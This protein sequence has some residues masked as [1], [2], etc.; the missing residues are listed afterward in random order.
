MNDSDIR[1]TI[2]IPRNKIRI[3]KSTLH[4]IN[5][6]THIVLV[7]NPEERTLGLKQCSPDEKTAHRINWKVMGNN[8]CELSSKSL[9]RAL[10]DVCPEWNVNAGYSLEG[11]LIP[12]ENMAL[13]EMDKAKLISIRNG[14]N[15][16]TPTI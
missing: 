14:K 12:G 7:V 15:G 11:T 5:D 4:A 1:I 2:D 13:F 3:F 8:C 6:P 16:K 9:I 10:M